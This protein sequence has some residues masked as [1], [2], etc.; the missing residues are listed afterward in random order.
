MEEFGRDEE[1]FI[2][3]P[4]YHD[5]CSFYISQIGENTRF[6]SPEL[7]KRYPEI[8][9]DDITETRNAIAHGYEGLDLDIIWLSINKKIPKLKKTCEKILKELKRS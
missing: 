8:N 2:E 3:N 4:F 7:T 9:W 5:V 1:D 6:L